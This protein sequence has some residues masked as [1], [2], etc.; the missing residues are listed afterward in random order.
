M[1]GTGVVGVGVVVDVLVKGFV[2]VEDD[3]PKE[4]EEMDEVKTHVFF[5]T[6]N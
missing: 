2:A 4:E 3:D 5:C 6:E 1:G